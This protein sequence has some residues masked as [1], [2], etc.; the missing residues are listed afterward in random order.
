MVVVLVLVIIIIVL[1][2]WG[3]PY[4]FWLLSTTEQ[5]TTASIIIDDKPELRPWAALLRKSLVVNWG[6]FPY[7]ELNPKYFH[8]TD[9][10]TGYEII[11]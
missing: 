1:M 11:K 5:G 2:A 4:E 7:S 6:I 9:T 8:F 3:T 10:T